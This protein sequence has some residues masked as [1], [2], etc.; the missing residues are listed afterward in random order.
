MCAE[1]KAVRWLTEVSSLILIAV[2]VSQWLDDRKV[3]VCIQD[4]LLNFLI[5][6]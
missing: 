3:R 5:K 6:G 1:R 2:I 4:A